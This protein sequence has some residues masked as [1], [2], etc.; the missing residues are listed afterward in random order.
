MTFEI[1]FKEARSFTLELK[2]A[3][4]YQTEEE[5]EIYVNDR[6]VI[7]TNK[8]VQTVD[9]L[10]PDTEYRI[11]VKQGELCSETALLKTDY[12]SYTLNVRDFGALGDGQRDDTGSIQAA[13]YSCPRDGRVLIPKGVYKITSLFMKS[14][15]RF[16]LAEGAVLSA[17]TER[18]KFP[19]LPGLIESY[20]ESGEYNLGT[21]EGNPLDM[22]AAIITCINVSNVM[23]YGKGTIDGCANHD[24]WWKNPKQKRIAWRPRQIFMNHCENMTVQGICVTNSPSWNLH[25][26]FSKN[27]RFIDL[28]ILNPK[29][30]PNTDGLDPE[31][32]ENVEIIGVYFSLGDDCIAIK[33]GK[34]YM[35]A[36]Y[37]TSSRNLMIRQCCM[38]DGHGSITIGSEMAAGVL[39][40][41]VKDCL[42]L[43]TDRGLRIKTRRGRGEAAVIDDIVF[44]NIRM[45]HV[46]TPFVINSFYFCDPDGYTEY[47]RTKEK[48]PVDERTPGIRKLAFRDI[49]CENCHVAAAFMYGLPERRIERVEMKN[50]SVGYAENPMVG[51]PA[52]MEGITPSRKK[53][54]YANNIAELIIENV[55]IRG[56]EGEELVTEHIGKLTIDGEQKQSD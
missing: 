25:P 45:D 4:I 20:D 18:E 26:Y 1:I 28:Q 27:L 10:K 35:G 24:N 36:K 5:Y 22:F 42:F 21:W 2:G 6:P 51:V 33:S 46:M 8:I 49:V 48:L 54:I 12:E 13:I 47:V 31:S 3:G 44:E 38:R 52:M 39:N 29:D 30:S 9:G 16:E 23:I 55:S 15:M 53:G 14:D 17:I 40:L 19:V 50:I 37:R 41:T 11:F 7:K 32:C 43:N 34:I 56:C